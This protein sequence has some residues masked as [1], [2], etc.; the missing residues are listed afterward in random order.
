[1]SSNYKIYI[2]QMY[3]TTI[4]SRLIRLFTHYKYTHIAISFDKNCNTLY[5]FGRKKFDS[6]LNAG[7]SI[8][9]K[10]GKFY[11][12]FKDTLCR[13]YELTVNKEQYIK[14]KKDILSIKKESSKYKYDY[15][16]I[17]ARF[18][19]ITIYFRNKYVCS[20]FIAELLQRAGIYKFEKESYFIEP[21]DFE[22]LD[23]L[24]EIYC[25][26]YINYNVN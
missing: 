5:S 21:K 26:K 12:K 6:I 16:G 19:R 9:N 11:R 15:T 7:F 25:G 2:L 20:Y 18:F 13:I 8:E 4:P 23:N 22:K 24:K 1:M 10:K 17:V 3:S 14:L